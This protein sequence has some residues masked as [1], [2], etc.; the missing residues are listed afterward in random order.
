MKK[1]VLLVIVFASLSLSAFAQDTLWTR[2]YGGSDLDAAKCVQQTQD[3][4]YIMTGLTDT[5]GSGFRSLWLVRTDANGDTLWTRTYG[6]DG[7]DVG[8]YVIEDSEGDFVFTGYIGA[9]DVTIHADVWLMKVDSNG[10]SLWSHSF[11][12]DSLDERGV[13][14]VETA[15][16]GYVVAGYRG[17]SLEAYNSEV[18]LLK[19]DSDG[20]LQWLETY[21]P[22][23][24]MFGWGLGYSVDQTADSGYIITGYAQDENT[25]NRDLYLIKTDADGDSLWARTYGGEYDEFGWSVEETS[26]SGFIIAGYTESFG[27]AGTNFWLLKTDSDGDSLWARTY[28]GEIGGWGFH[29]HQTTDGGY[30][31][32]GWFHGNGGDAW[33]L[34][35]DEYG[36]TS[37]TR[38]YGGSQYEALSAV[39]QTSDGWYV[40]CGW[41][42]SFGAGDLDFY[43]L[44]MGPGEQPVICGDVN[45][46]AEANITDAVYLVNYLF[47]D[48]DPPECPPFPYDSCADANGDGETT[49]SD[50]VYLINYLFKSGPDPKC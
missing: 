41:A 42:E 11:G 1:V 49:I 19:T 35:T 28:G 23:P 20:N 48:G 9:L 34:K 10:D 4:G 32:S 5:Y 21:N 40:A 16:S 2:T 46:D 18:L 45:D 15:D 17:F 36:D 14:L 47:K 27:D 12:E 6:T 25:A 37:W 43:L 24:T 30:I 50:V 13:W 38:T 29:A 8:N 26:D 31:L 33:L 22:D 39:Q 7:V 3:G 44:K